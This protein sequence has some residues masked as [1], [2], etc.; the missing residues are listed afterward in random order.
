MTEYKGVNYTIHLVGQGN[1]RKAEE[2]EIDDYYVT[3]KS[4]E[5]KIKEKEIFP[6]EQIKRIEV[7]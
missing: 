7:H 3:V 1:V 2:M 5:N 6:R 4:I